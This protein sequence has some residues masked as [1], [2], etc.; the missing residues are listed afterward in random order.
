MTTVTYQFPDP[1]IDTRRLEED[2]IFWANYREQSELRSRWCSAVR[3]IFFESDLC[4]GVV[5]STIL[6]ATWCN[7]CFRH[8]LHL[9]SRSSVHSRKRDSSLHCWQRSPSKSLDEASIHV[10]VFAGEKVCS[11]R[12]FN[13][14]PF[15]KIPGVC[16][17]CSK[18]KREWAAHDT[19]C[20]LM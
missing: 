4:G 5:S 9:R 2:A 15:L 7:V 12:S 6:H 8:A 13:Y 11:R 20:P 1:I 14:F 18:K 19:C 10:H 16:D 3:S 17:K